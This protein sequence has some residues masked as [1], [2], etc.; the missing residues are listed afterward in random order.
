MRVL[1]VED[2]RDLADAIARACAGRATRSTSLTAATRRSMKARVYPYDLICLDL[3]LPAMGGRE[4]CRALRAEQRRT[5]RR[6]RG[7]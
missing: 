4:V 6:S 3:N 2:E 7:S 1:V 5:A